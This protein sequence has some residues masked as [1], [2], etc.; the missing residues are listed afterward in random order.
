MCVRGECAF[1]GG[2]RTFALRC[3][4]FIFDCRFF[5]TAITIAS[6]ETRRTSPTTTLLAAGLC[7][8]TSAGWLHEKAETA[9]GPCSWAVSR[10]TG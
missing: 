9:Q 8:A 1:G 2:A 3:R 5:G 4:V 10:C 7:M 6:G